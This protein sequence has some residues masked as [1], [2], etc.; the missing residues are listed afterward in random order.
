MYS[1]LDTLGEEHDSVVTRVTVWLGGNVQGKGARPP[2]AEDMS[3]K[4]SLH[5]P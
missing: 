4:S 1:L 5:W 3:R 2:V